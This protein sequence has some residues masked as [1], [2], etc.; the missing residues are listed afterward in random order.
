M[1][2]AEDAGWAVRQH[3][4]RRLLLP[5]GRFGEC[6]SVISQSMAELIVGEVAPVYS[7]IRPCGDSLK[8][9]AGIPAIARVDDTNRLSELFHYDLNSGRHVR[10]VRDDNRV[11][12]VLLE[13][14]E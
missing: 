5:R 3:M 8:V 6:S 4:A 2:T 10:V 11:V 7:G 12:E 9:A 13:T 1:K 14:V